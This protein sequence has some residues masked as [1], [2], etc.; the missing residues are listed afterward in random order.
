MASIRISASGFAAS[1][2]PPA[3]R[4]GLGWLILPLTLAACL[5]LIVI[6]GLVALETTYTDRVAARVRTLDTDLGGRTRDEARSVLNAEVAA[7]LRQPIRLAAGE[8][9]WETT[10]RELG[11]GLDV[12]ALVN[13]AYVIG[14]DEDPWQRA[15]APWMALLWREWELS[16]SAEFDRERLRGQLESYALAFDRSAVDARLE[17]DMDPDGSPIAVITPE[18]AGRRLLIASSASRVIDALAGGHTNPIEMAVQ[19][20]PAHVNAIDLESAQREANQILSG[21]ITLA[22]DD[23]EWTIHPSELAAALSFDQAPSS[24]ASISFD[25]KAL[26]TRFAPIQHY[27]SRAPVDAR[28]AWNGGAL[29][30]LRESEDGRTLDVEALERLIGEAVYTDDRVV[31]I[32]AVVSR[33]RVASADAAELGI[34]QL[35]KQGRTSFAGAGAE[36]QHNVRLAASRLNGV[37]VP[38]GATFSFNREVGPTTLAAGFQSAWGITSSRDGHQTVP[39]VAGGICQVATTLFQPVF[40]AGYPIE[41]RSYHLYWIPSYGQAPLGMKG[42]DATV[43][44]EY[45]LDLQFIN[46]TPDH[47][48]I[49]ARVEGINLIFD[50]YGTRPDWTVKIDAPA[51]S[52]VVAASSETVRRPEPTL[53]AGRSVAVETA[54]DGFDVTITRTVTQGDAVRVL[55]L[56]SRYVPAQNVILDG[57]RPASR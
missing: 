39:S 41:Q 16:P 22:Y 6:V 13:E 52:K 57:T 18:R 20:T 29:S 5:G 8:A 28:L 17:I 23:Q 33:P 34:T 53:P 9:R 35:I 4:W 26:R 44:E 37:V 1:R 40:H 47:L 25:P 32:P 36:K 42:L 55:P 11:M 3:R 45:G 56:R 38:P 46:S 19:A 21:P 14:R 31:S 30:V 50:L 7:R 49:Q 27:L 12:D 24:L 10:A 43:D 2:R 15:L 54:H 48:L 51:I